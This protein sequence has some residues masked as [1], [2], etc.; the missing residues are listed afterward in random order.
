MCGLHTEMYLGKR[1]PENDFL[2]FSLRQTLKPVEKSK[3]NGRTTHTH[4]HTQQIHFWGK[5]TFFNALNA[6]S[7]IS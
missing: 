3:L 6:F 1:Y 7:T 2:K 5:M 4:T